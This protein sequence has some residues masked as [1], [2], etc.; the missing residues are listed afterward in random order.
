MR[1]FT[2]LVVFAMLC[3]FSVIHAHDFVVGGIYYKV[4]TGTNN[5]EVTYNSDNPVNFYRGEIIV[6]TN[7]IYDG[8]AYNVVKIGDFS[9]G[10]CHGLTSITMSENIISIGVNAFFG[11][12]S[13][14]SIIIPNSV[15]NIGNSAFSS[16]GLI[17]ITLPNSITNIGEK[18]FESCDSLTSVTISNSITHISNSAFYGCRKLTSITIPNSVTSIGD[19]AF[20]LS[21]LIF[22]ELPNSIT[23]IGV[24]AFFGCYSL[25]SATLPIGLNNIEQGCDNLKSIII[26]NGVE[27][28]GEQAFYACNS[29]E[30]IIIPK[31]VK[32]IGFRAFAGCLSLKEV[33]VKWENP[34]IIPVFDDIFEWVDIS[35]VTLIIP[36][37]TKHLYQIA[38]V[39]KNFG[40]IMSASE[41]STFTLTVNNGSG[42][43]NYAAGV[44]VLI[45]ANSPPFGQVFAQWIGDV[46]GIGNINSA[47][48]TFTMWNSNA[49]VTATYK[50]IPATIYTLTVNNGSGS[51]NYTAG[52]LV[53]ISAN[54]PPEG[55]EFD[56]WIGDA[57]RIADINNASTIFTMGNTNST[58][59]AMYKDIE[60]AVEIVKSRQIKFY[61]FEGSLFIESEDTMQRIELYNLFGQ[62]LKV[63]D[64]RE[65]YV[66]IQGLPHGQIVFVKVTKNEKVITQKLI[67]SKSL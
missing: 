11:C 3:S 53:N 58:V 55:K 39:W 10:A 2:L 47:N 54:T 43:G 30:S 40:N 59:T 36:E 52:K 64:V 45:I 67:I 27:S 38:D 49:S 42:S 18:I 56:K 44:S 61:S 62:L 57:N 26:P 16:S 46:S 34:A 22:I 25:T 23:N 50:D 21:G 41:N 51:G 63:I 48:T 24:Q 37:N 28:I 20:T 60:T 13:L 6:P 32:N 66:E 7:V 1:K 33:E 4:I 65:K 19:F 31:N 15:T 8:I 17:S 35:L 9:F 29:L 5:V 14:K 12:S